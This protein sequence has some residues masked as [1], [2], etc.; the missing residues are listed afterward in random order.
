MSVVPQKTV[1][2]TFALTVALLALGCSLLQ[3]VFG[4]SETLKETGAIVCLAGVVAAIWLVV[5]L[6]LNTVGQAVGKSY[7]S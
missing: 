3:G 7:R 2:T 4:E 1:L 5:L 6:F